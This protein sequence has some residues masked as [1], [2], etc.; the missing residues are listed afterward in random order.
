MSVVSLIRLSALLYGIGSVCLPPKFIQRVSFGVSRQTG[1]VMS[2]REIEQRISH[3]EFL[4]QR[5]LRQ[6]RPVQVDYADKSLVV[7]RA[8]LQDRSRYV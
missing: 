7:L 5:F 1:V 8:R 3:Y 4:K 6:N 2:K